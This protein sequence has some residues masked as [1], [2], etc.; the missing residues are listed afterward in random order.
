MKLHICLSAF[1]LEGAIVRVGSESNRDNLACGTIS[2]DMINANQKIEVTC[3]LYGQYLSIEL[4]SSKPLTLCEVQA[5]K[6]Q[7]QGK[8]TK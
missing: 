6:G 5:F 8:Q 2:F 4:N 3:D 1:R 7:C